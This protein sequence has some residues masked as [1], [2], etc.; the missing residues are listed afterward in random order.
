MMG[1]FPQYGSVCHG[2]TF[3]SPLLLPLFPHLIHWYIA[4]Y[5]LGLGGFTYSSWYSISAS[6]YD[7]KPDAIN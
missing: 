6:L 1:V 4:V 3:A 7:S 2:H 5:V